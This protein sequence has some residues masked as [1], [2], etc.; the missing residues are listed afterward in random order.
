MV[1]KDLQYQVGT[2]A[3]GGSAVTFGTAKRSLAR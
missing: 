1:N 2:L 3:F